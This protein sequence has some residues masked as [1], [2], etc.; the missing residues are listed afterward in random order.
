VERDTVLGNEGSKT[1]QMRVNINKNPI[2]VSCGN[3][4]GGEY[5]VVGNDSCRGKKKSNSY[6]APLVSRH[7]FAKSGQLSGGFV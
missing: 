5:S 1:P 6:C 4:G 7:F 2:C 3:G